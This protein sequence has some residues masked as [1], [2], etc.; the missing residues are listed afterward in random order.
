MTLDLGGTEL[1]QTM[2][3]QLKENDAVVLKVNEG[4]NLLHDAKVD[5]K[6][7]VSIKS[8]ER[9]RLF[10]PELQG[11]RALD[12]LCIAAGHIWTP[13][14]TGG[15]GMFFCLSGILVISSMHAGA[16]DGSGNPFQ[17]VGRA[18]SRIL[19]EGL[20]LLLFTVMMTQMFMSPLYVETLGDATYASVMLINWRFVVQRN[21]YFSRNTE[22]SPLLLYWSLS[23]IV[24]AYFFNAVFYSLLGRFGPTSSITRDLIGVAFQVIVISLSAGYMAYSYIT[25]TIQLACT[26]SHP[27]PACQFPSSQMS[28]KENHQLHK[29]SS[30]PHLSSTAYTFN[31]TFMIDDSTKTTTNFYSPPL[32]QFSITHLPDATNKDFETHLWLWMFSLGCLVGRSVDSVRVPKALSI[33]FSVAAAGLTAVIMWFIFVTRLVPPVFRLGPPLTVVL[34]LFAGTAE[35]THLVLD[36]F[37]LPVLAHLGGRSYWIFLLHW[38]LVVAWRRVHPGVVEIPQLAAASILLIVVFIAEI[39]GTAFDSFRKAT[40][41]HKVNGARATKL[42]VGL[43]LCTTVGLAITW[44]R[45]GDRE[46]RTVASTIA[47]LDTGYGGGYDSSWFTP[48]VAEAQVSPFGNSSEA[49]GNL[50]SSAIALSSQLANSTEAQ[51]HSYSSATTLSGLLANSNGVLNHSADFTSEK[52]RVSGLE[53]LPQL[54]KWRP[55]WPPPP[56]EPP[57]LFA[58]PFPGAQVLLPNFHSSSS[59]KSSGSVTA[60]AGYPLSSGCGD[61]SIQNMQLNQCHKDPKSIG[62]SFPYPHNPGNFCVHGDVDNWK[63]AHRVVLFGASHVK[64]WGPAFDI[65]AKRHGW[66]IINYYKDGCDV[67]NGQYKNLRNDPD[68]RT[69]LLHAT[70]NILQRPPT[71]VVGLTGYSWGKHGEKTFDSE[72][73]LVK[74]VRDPLVTAGVQFVLFRDIPHFNDEKIRPSEQLCDEFV[75]HAMAKHWPNSPSSSFAA[76]TNVVHQDPTQLA[77]ARSANSTTVIDMTDWI[78]PPLSSQERFCPLV[79]G[80]V[81]VMMDFHHLSP[82]F[83]RSL[84]DGLELELKRAS[85]PVKLVFKEGPTSTHN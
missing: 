13:S 41:D 14:A 59:L 52:T 71:V 37:R 4:E 82:A 84:T 21:D 63:T 32:T 6:E 20:A 78:C 25:A 7:E 50:F 64:Q 8:N 11:L 80:N 36:L 18:L 44:Q 34:V 30:L 2:A 5:L 66:L 65:L 48:P 38:P 72:W 9:K 33:L 16:L 74:K 53:Q 54:S 22:G 67:D 62:E 27:P 35:G 23:V 51:Q 60:S 15:V 58:P 24:Q 75:A 26:Y 10:R 81:M 43:A 55:S 3:S 57:V 77:I 39:C 70:E 69:F 47:G 29:H 17:G 40:L 28:H 45:E 49:K 31:T 76:S 19:P 83:V 68:C 73:E 1:E 61:A 46:K 79:M 56:W 12:A 42:G 85:P